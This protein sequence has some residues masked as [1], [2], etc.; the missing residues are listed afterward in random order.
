[1]DDIK[2]AFTIF[3]IGMGLIVWGFFGHLLELF[4]GEILIILNLQ[5]HSAKNSNIKSRNSGTHSLHILHNF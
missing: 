2:S 3:I 4:G 5:L 1:M